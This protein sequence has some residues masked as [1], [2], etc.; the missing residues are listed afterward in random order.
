MNTAALKCLLSDLGK[1]DVPMELAVPL[2]IIFYLSRMRRVKRDK[3]LSAAAPDVHYYRHGRANV[4]TDFL[5]QIPFF[6]KPATCL[7]RLHSRAKGH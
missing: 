5:L 6:G 7:L 3:S 4:H 2:L 1:M